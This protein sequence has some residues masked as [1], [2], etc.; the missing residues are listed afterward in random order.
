MKKDLL[1]TIWIMALTSSLLLVGMFLIRWI[2]LHQH[3]V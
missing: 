3:H 2:E 1:F